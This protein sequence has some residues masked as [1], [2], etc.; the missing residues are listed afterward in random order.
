MTATGVAASVPKVPF[1]TAGQWRES[2]SQRLGD[3]FNPSTGEL[4]GQV[5]LSSDDETARVVAAA[6]EA[7]PGWS[8]TPP[9]DRARILFRFR[10]LLEQ[11]QE[12]LAQLVTREHGKT[13]PEARAEVQRG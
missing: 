7:L 2:A 12:S 6:A 8:E 5:P 9:V 11:H 10:G 3:V 4:I 13:L 1:L